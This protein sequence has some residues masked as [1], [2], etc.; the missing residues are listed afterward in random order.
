MDDDVDTLGR[1]MGHYLA[2]RIAVAEEETD[3]EEH[4]RLED[5]CCKLIMEL[6]RHRATLP[7]RVRPLAGLADII[8][9]IADLSTNM[10]PYFGGPLQ[11]GETDLVPWLEFAKKVEREAAEVV[12]IAIRQ[13]LSESALTADAERAE[14]FREFLSRDETLVIEE[15]LLL[16]EGTRPRI[17]FLEDE[18]AVAAD[19]QERATQALDALD[20][21]LQRLAEGFETLK[22]RVRV[23]ADDSGEKA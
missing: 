4:K 19:P 17:S 13:A 20:V 7:D 21:R 18:G 23:S 11:W 2:E 1:W 14:K 8:R 10:A 15:L 5:E 16:Q 12:R 3:P 22:E 9:V 6:W